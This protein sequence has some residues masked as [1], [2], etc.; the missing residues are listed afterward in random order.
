MSIFDLL[1]Y[2]GVVFITAVGYLMSLIDRRI[3]AAVSGRREQSVLQPYFIL[4]AHFIKKK[5]TVPRNSEVFFFLILPVLALASVMTASFIFLR[6]AISGTGFGGD[7][8]VVGYLILMARFFFLVSG[9]ASSSGVSSNAAVRETERFMMWG[10]AAGFSAAVIF[11][12]TAG[13]ISITEIMEYQRTSGT[14]LFSLSGLTAF[15]VLSLAAQDSIRQ[16]PYDRGYAEEQYGQ[17]VINEY[18][19]LPLVFFILYRWILLGLYPFMIIAVFSGKVG[20]VWGLL[21]FLLVA[22]A[23]ILIKN[24]R[25]GYDENSVAGILSR[26]VVAVS[27]AGAVLA[28]VGL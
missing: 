26:T 21:K 7:L 6:S 27:L 14:V 16:I 17:G 4:K 23:I 11:M 28:S 8:V 24:I 25:P 20:S 22:T 15:I 12:K 18:N 5:L 3:Y 2:P 13:S 19:G 1:I 10:I 9:T